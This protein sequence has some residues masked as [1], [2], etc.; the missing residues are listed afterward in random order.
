MLKEN[1][2]MLHIIK[3]FNVV[4]QKNILIQINIDVYLKTYIVYI[5]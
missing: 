4:D 5:I 2:L 3:I 1:I